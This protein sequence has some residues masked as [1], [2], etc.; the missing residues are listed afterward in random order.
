MTP[1]E[2]A[3]RAHDVT[4]CL[5]RTSVPEFEELSLLGRAVK[6]A[7]H[8]RGVPAV[9][10]EV[11][12]NIAIYILNFPPSA[13]RPTIELLAEAEFVELDVD[14]RTI[15]TVVPSIPFYEKIFTSL[16]TVAGSDK[17]SEPEKLTLELLH[18]LASS[19]LVRDNAYQ[20]GAERKVVDRVLDVGAETSFIIQKRARGRDVLLSPTYFSETPQA[21]ADL[22]AGHGGGRV[23]RVLRLI[24]ESQGWPL[25]IIEKKHEL[26]GSR[27]DNADLSVIRALAGQGFLPPPAIQTSYR[28]T[29]Y[30]LFG[31]RPGNS[32]LPAAKRPVY[33]AAMALVSAVRQG[34]LL[35]NRYKINSPAALLLS[36]KEK[37]F[38]N[39]NTEAMEQYRQ[40]CALNVGRLVRVNATTWARFVLIDRPENHEALDLAMLLVRGGEPQ[41][42]S[43][44]EVRLAI[45][46]GERYVESLIGR[47]RLVQEAVVSPDE[48]SL[49]TIDDFLLKGRE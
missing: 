12:R 17:F 24:R 41:I 27:L 23:D 42:G 14:G 9:S 47:K 48:E 46:K 30:F 32:R 18:R 35:P 36:L 19:P 39:A 7:L 1:E 20:L 6:L 34:Q 26:S 37:G 43:S 8:L 10:Y 13:V 44:D 33:E 16:A 11:L 28:G 15:K 2:A 49:A 45:L 31:P 21:Y 5:E 22:V 40:V 3:I 38:L 29:N 4:V 25:A